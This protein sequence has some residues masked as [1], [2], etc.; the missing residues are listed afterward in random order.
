M[1]FIQ[2]NHQRYLSIA[3]LIGISAVSVAQQGSLDEPSLAAASMPPVDCV[4]SPHKVIDLS[5]PVPGVVENLL[6]ERSDYVDENQVV[7]TLASRVEQASVALAKKRA[8]IEAEVYLEQINLDF[9]ERQQ[10]RIDMLYDTDAVSY[11]NKDDADRE[12]E[13]STWKLQQARDLV[14]VRKLEL[15]RAY[16][17][18]EQKTVRSPISGFVVQT[19]KAQGEYVEDQ[20]VVRIAQLDP[21]KV[22]AIVP[23]DMFG[24]VEV[25]MVAKVRL[26]TL[27]LPTQDATV[28]IVDK[29]GDAAS[30]TFGVRLSLPNPEN[31]IPAGLKCDLN[32]LPV[33]NI[34]DVDSEVEQMDSNVHSNQKETP[35]TEASDIA[36]ALAQQ[37]MVEGNHNRE[38][39]AALSP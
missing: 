28:T 13:L 17:Q 39:F 16:Q 35:A 7:A 2:K 30:G 5:S 26:E 20:P 18:L 34:A 37:T 19:F 21:L 36:P 11:Q 9:A 8:E 3:V 23:I 27:S 6:A 22:D 25:G 15:N 33:E 12:V 32:F 10:K 14:S 24:D 31:K 29:M 38:S 4:V 1:F